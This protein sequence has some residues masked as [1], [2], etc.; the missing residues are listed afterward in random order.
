MKAGRVDCFPC[1]RMPSKIA[2]YDGLPTIHTGF[3][4]RVI[5]RHYA[6]FLLSE[7]VKAVVL[8]LFGGLFV[9]SVISIQ[10]VELGL[11]ERLALPRDSYLIDYFNDLHRYLEIGPPV[12]FV[13]Q[14]GD[15]TSRAG[16]RELCGR[17]TTCEPFSLASVL[18]VERK[19]ADTSFIGM[20]TSS[21]LDDFFLWLNPAMDTCCRVRKANPSQFCAA[22]DSE[23]L[24]QPC[25]KN[26]TPAWNVTMEGLPQGAEF[27]RYLKQWLITPTND[28]CYLGGQASYGTALTINDS[29]NRIEA[30]HFRTFHTPLRTQAD[31]IGAFSAAHRI[32]NDI[33]RRTGLTVFPYSSFYVFFDQYAHI[34]GVTQE[35]LGLGLASVLVVTAVLLGSWRTGTIVT[36]VVALTVT[37]VMGVMGLWGINLNA[38][39]VVNLVISLGIAV[40]FCSHI[41][42][43]F[44][45]AGVGLPVDH[46]GGQRERDERMWIA[47]VDVG[48]SVGKPVVLHAPYSALPGSLGYHVYQAHRH[49]GHG[50]DKVET[51]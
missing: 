30:S 41:A 16:Q 38:V 7:S 31:F 12:Y 17:F 18:E 10:R 27:M 8:V 5:R 25:L 48:P 35:V 19:R 23:R 4:A 15:E 50:L 49:V 11:D 51:T 39:S 14:D 26:Q 43:A 33:S 9:A 20:P 46:P 37:T 13:V 45:G 32:A 22:R 34:I 29:V 21:W 28:I 36:G 3:L 47:L 44:M 40:E 24:C 42:R 1:I 6:P 2:L